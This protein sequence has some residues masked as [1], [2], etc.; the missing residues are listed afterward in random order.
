MLRT[1]IVPRGAWWTVASFRN[2][3]SSEIGGLQVDEHARARAVPE[4]KTTRE[5]GSRSCG[6]FNVRR[7]Y[8]DQG[9]CRCKE[10]MQETCRQ[11]Q[12]QRWVMKFATPG[13]L[14]SNVILIP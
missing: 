10:W 7:I 9:A 5:M 12:G 6:K 1:S 11:E 8:R 4:F 13:I 2:L 14:H 3:A